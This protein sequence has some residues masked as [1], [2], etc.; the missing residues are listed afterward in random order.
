MTQQLKSALLV[1]M[2]ITLLGGA[3]YLTGK[4][5]EVHSQSR[6]TISVTGTGKVSGKPDIAVLQFGV[7]TGRQASAQRALTVLAQNMDKITQTMIEFGV[8]TEDIAT[9]SLW[10]N[11]AFDW[12]DGQQISKGFEATQNVNVKVRDL[13]KIGNILTKA[14]GAG[15]NQIGGVTL[16]IDN[17][18][19]VR[20]QAREIA[21]K[22]ARTKA[23]ALSKQLG[24]RLGKVV[25]YTDGVVGAYDNPAMMGGVGMGGGGG[26]DLSVPTGSQDVIVNVTVSYE[27]R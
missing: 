15:A 26:A 23:D 21:L 6:E 3:I 1:P 10:L 12:I 16:T 2:A 20:A 27:I 7:N 17:P 9:Q 8:D 4:T 14:A 22:N 13:E 24:V 11:P 19:D 25:S 5:M 18:E